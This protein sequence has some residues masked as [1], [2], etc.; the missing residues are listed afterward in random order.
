VQFYEEKTMN[1]AGLLK[2]DEAELAEHYPSPAER[3]ADGAVHA[4][5]LALG[6]IGGA[7]LFAMALTND[8]TSTA[9]AVAL[10]SVSVILMLVC[11]AVYN[12]TRPS[13]ARRLLRRLDEGAIFM[14][15]AGSCTP[16]V[17][18]LVPDEWEA[19]QIGA[20]WTLAFAGAAGKVLRPDWS[21]QVWTRLYVAFAALAMAPLAPVAIA[22]LPPVCLL[23]LGLAAAVYVLGTRIYLDHRARYR[24]A[25]WH[26]MVVAGAAAHYGALAT[27]VVLPGA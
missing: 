20:M 2:P 7:V 19:L 5:G 25:I 26:T 21:D 10:Y 9:G 17:I 4:I 6:A 22:M 18:K 14:M 16:L 12:L 23:M 3:V 8:G 24:R 13:Q 11:S 15:I 27:G 1:L